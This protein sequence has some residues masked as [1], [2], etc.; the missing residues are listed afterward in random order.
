MSLTGLGW[1]LELKSRR[2][3]P[4]GTRQLMGHLSVPCF[5]IPSSAQLVSTVLSPQKAQVLSLWASWGLSESGA[6]SFCPHLSS[7]SEAPVVRTAWGD[8]V[9]AVG[10]LSRGWNQWDVCIRSNL[11]V[12]QAELILQCIRPPR[13]PRSLWGGCT[14]P[15]PLLSVP[16]ARLREALTDG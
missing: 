8:E 11:H 14:L 5:P 2:N 3:Q 7:C 10:C 6:A 4:L 12:P 1:V 9:G 13:L 15:L 16:R